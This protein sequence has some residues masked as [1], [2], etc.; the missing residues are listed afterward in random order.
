MKRLLDIVVSAVLLAVLAPVMAALA[1][2]VACTIGRP[3]LFRQQRPG[4]HGRPF[5][6][7]K[8][9][10][11]TDARDSSGALLPDSARLTIAGR[12]LRASSLDELPELL[13]VLKGDMSLVGPRPLLTRYMPYYTRRERIRHSVRPGMTGWAQVRGRNS[14][15]WDQRLA[16]DVWYVRNRSLWL[17]AKIVALT[18]VAL[19]RRKG[20]VVDP[21]LAML[22]LDEERAGVCPETGREEVTQ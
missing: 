4:L 7:C 18:C 10:T 6:L 8:Y 21:S 16:D 12:L 1:A 3:I 5:G 14:S 22:D 15:S 11:M 9:R 2:V 19:I 13:N 20:L 17:D